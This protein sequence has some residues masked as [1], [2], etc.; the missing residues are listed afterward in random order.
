MTR[1]L[2]IG[3][4]QVK[5]GWEILNANEFDG[6]D[7]VMNAMDLS[8]FED[9]TFSEIYSSHVVEH[10]D[11]R[12]ELRPV[13][14][15]WYRVLKPGGKMM[16]S[17]PDLDILCA[18]MMDKKQLDTAHRWKIMIMMF[19]AHVDQY[20]FH[21]VGLNFEFLANILMDEQ[22]VDIQR[23]KSFGLFDDSSEY[24]FV[25]VPISLNVIANKAMN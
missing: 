22:F 25:G 7:H 13:L 8:A 11:F 18:M 10:F 16:V 23:V 19:G 20:D 2:H 6:V 14:R 12:G 15:E 9:G 24:K 5:E 21:K 1:K 4:K 17:V 3:G